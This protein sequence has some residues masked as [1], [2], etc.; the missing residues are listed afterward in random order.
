[1]SDLVGNPK[2]RF[3]LVAA[4]F[5]HTQFQFTAFICSKSVLISQ[6]REVR[7]GRPGPEVIKLFSSPEPKAH[8]VSL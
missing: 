2:D 4:L 5:M 6:I 8:K 7:I 1:M 3:S